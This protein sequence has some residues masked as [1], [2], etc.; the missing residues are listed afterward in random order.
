MS[1]GSCSA[2]CTLILLNAFFLVVSLVLIAVGSVMQ[3]SFHAYAQVF[4]D[5]V[6]VP[7]VL[8]ISLGLLIC[9]TSIFGLVIVVRERYILLSVYSCVLVILVIAETFIGLVGLTLKSYVRQIVVHTMQ[10]AERKYNESISAAYTWN[11]IQ[12]NLHCCG[13]LN[14]TEW[15]TYLNNSVPD[16]CCISYKYNCGINAVEAN[17]VHAT[18]C[19]KA[20]FH[21]LYEH[22]IVIGVLCA[23]FV[24][25]KIL[26]LMLARC[27]G[28]YLVEFTDQP[29]LNP[30][31]TS[32]W[33]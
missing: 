20:L 13:I 6:S 31:K 26:T 32:I 30:F 7:A 21:W 4:R 9:M 23:A 16:S 12:N 5:S 29:S 3:V 24:L 19:A 17:N 33:R 2:K 22:Q 1:M 10:V 27:Y 28:R 14:Y 25:L 11:T 15:S 8:I 18:G